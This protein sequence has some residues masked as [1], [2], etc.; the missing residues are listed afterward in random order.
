MLKLRELERKDLK[1]INEWRNDPNLI[2]FLGPPFRF[3]NIEVDEKWFDTYMA[4]RAVNVR[5]AI[6]DDSDDIIKG[7]V[8]LNS[9]DY[10]N[11][12]AE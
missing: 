2:S 3:I 6:V 10:L 8:S 7:V 5:C 9:I 4:N 12:S 1:I 11:Q